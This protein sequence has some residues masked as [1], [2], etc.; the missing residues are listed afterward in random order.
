MNTSQACRLHSRRGHLCQAAEAT[1]QGRADYRVRHR[2]VAH[3]LG[4]QSA[5]ARAEPGRFARRS[6]RS[7]VLAAAFFKVLQNLENTRAALNRIVEMKN[8]MRGVF[9]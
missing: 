2:Q 1:M 4:S 5:D 8:Q 7:L 6:Y 3:D 9:Q